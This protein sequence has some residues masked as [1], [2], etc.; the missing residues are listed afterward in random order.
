MYNLYNWSLYVFLIAGS[1][2]AD[3]SDKNHMK[4][5]PKYNNYSTHVHRTQVELC[6][7]GRVP[8]KT[9]SLGLIRK[10]GILM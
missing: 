8:M 4:L 9:G 6:G 7:K 10:L 2:D 1:N 3:C 5:P